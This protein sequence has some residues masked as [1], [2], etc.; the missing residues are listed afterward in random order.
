MDDPEGK[1]LNSVGFREHYCKSTEN[2]SI[3]CLQ[4][5]NF[6]SVKSNYKSK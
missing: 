6:E 4:V 5:Y 3:D 1:S 2:I